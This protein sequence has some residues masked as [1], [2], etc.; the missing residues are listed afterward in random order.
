LGENRPTQYG[1]Q[2]ASLMPARNLFIPIDKEKIRQNKVVPTTLPDSLIVPRIE[3]TVDG[4]YLMKDEIALL[5]IISTNAANGWERP[6]YFAVTCR[7]EKIMGIRDY[8]QLE[9]MGLRIVPV[10]TLSPG[11]Y[12]AMGMGRVEMDT[13][14]N[15]IMTKFRWG[16]FDKKEC[17]IDE[18]YMP[19]VHSIQFGMV[20]LASELAKAGQKEKAINILDKFFAAFPHMNFPLDDNRVAPQIFAM[21]YSLDAVDKAKPH[22]IEMYKALVEKQNFFDALKGSDAN[23]FEEEKQM[24][25]YLLDNILQLVAT[26]KDDAFQKELLDLS[27]S[28]DENFQKQAKQT[29]SAPPPP[30]TPMLEDTGK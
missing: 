22:M 20:R 14:Y 28:L 5:D 11:Q 21:Y 17:F 23:L 1:P 19:S 18:S 3:F 2:I 9:G 25:L 16:N 12:G 10:K 6:I 26:K 13:M 27:A 7:P 24:N 15:N 29:L 4:E 8:L 30:N